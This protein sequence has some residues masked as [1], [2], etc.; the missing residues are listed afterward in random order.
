MLGNTNRWYVSGYFLGVKTSGNQNTTNVGGTCV[1][2]YKATKD[3]IYNSKSYKIFEQD[4]IIVCAWAS[5]SSLSKALIR[6]DTLTKKIYMIHPDSI[7]ECVAM[8]FGMNVGDSIYLPYSPSSSVLKNGYYKL[9]SVNNKAEVL[10]LRRHLY[11]SKHN[12]PNNPFT[13]KKYYVEWIESIGAVHFPINIIEEGQNNDFNMP[14]SCKKNQYSSYVTCKYT[15][16]IKYYQDSCALKFVNTHAGYVLFGDNCAFY[17]YTGRVK[18][19][20]FLNEVQLFPNPSSSEQITL[21]FKALYFKPIDVSI[22][23]NVG[24]KMYNEKIS[25]TTTNN[26]IRLHDLKLRQGLYTLNI[27]SDEETSSI[28]FIITD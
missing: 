23:N 8:D 9:D 15:N 21:K 22:Y 1:G 20:S 26:E 12:A 3:S 27:K 13:N 11:L 25:I 14:F 18:E 7:N 6:E 16:G 19:L 4:Q 28:S 17:G 24:Q 10:G 5:G 2:Y